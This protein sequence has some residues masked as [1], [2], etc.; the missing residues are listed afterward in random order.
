MPLLVLCSGHAGRSPTTIVIKNLWIMFK[1]FR[2]IP[3]WWAANVTAR[4][5]KKGK[6]I[7]PLDC[8]SKTLTNYEHQ[9]H[10]L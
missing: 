9:N 10:F 5:T 1:A 6:G 7:F 2:K 3:C 4:N 8:Y